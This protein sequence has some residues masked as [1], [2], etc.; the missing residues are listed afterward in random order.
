MAMKQTAQK[1]PVASIEASAYELVFK[2]DAETPLDLVASQ[3]GRRLQ[4]RTA[5]RALAGMQKEALV[6]YGPT[7]AAWRIVCDEGP[8]LNGTDL[9]PFPL[10]YFG[11]GLT[12]SYISEFLTHARR[13]GI[14]ISGLEVMV[15][16]R[17]SMEGSLMRGTMVG[18]AFPVDVRFRANTSA[19]GE[20]VLKLG[21]LAVASSPADAVLRNAVDSLFTLNHNGSQVPVKKVAASPASQHPDP[22]PLFEQAAPPQP[23][24]FASDILERLDDMD[25]LGGEK[26]GTERASSNVGLSDNQKRQVH[27]RCVGTLRN[28]GMKEL[29]V[30]CFKPIG[31][32]FKLLSDDSVAVGGK[33]RAPSGL[34]YLSAGLSFCFMTQLGRYAHVA[35]HALHSYQIVQDTSF[36][37]PAAINDEETP[38]SSAAVTTDVFV[39]DDENSD[40]AG[41]LLN[42]GEQTCYLHA[43]CRSALKTR[44]RPS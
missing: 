44:I 34:A 24:D 16:N 14:E 10:G 43:A 33:E 32:V 30:A 18:S 29:Q 4:V 1:N 12:A 17:Y 2:Q 11:A 20:T 26:L 15:D 37:P 40:A 13:A 9:A 7:Q 39:A 23:P 19:D 27:V 36:S 3:Q 38:P 21:H 42:M 31:S 8:W 5:T 35:K 22:Y 25:T 6:S 41:T 28:D